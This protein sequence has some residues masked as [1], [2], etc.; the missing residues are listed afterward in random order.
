M[1]DKVFTEDELSEF[2]GS[3]VGKPIY[4]AYKGKVYD[5]TDSPLFIEGMHFEHPAGTDLSDFM[6]ESPHGDEVLEEFKVV[7]T[8]E[9]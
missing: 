1:S 7:G 9:E 2:D 8:F 6:E 3:D 5:V 4:F